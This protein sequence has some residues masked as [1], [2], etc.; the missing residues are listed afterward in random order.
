M[1]GVMAM[2]KHTVRVNERGVRIG[3]GHHNA[4]LTDAE[5]VQL[6]ADRGPDGA[7]A[8]SYSALAKRYGVSKSCVASLVQ[9]RTRE[10]SGV[11]V[12]RVRVVEPGQNIVVAQIR[13]TLADRALLI[14]LGG[15]KWVRKALASVRNKDRR[16]YL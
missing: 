7:P 15:A 5:V 9:G 1:L 3:E 13:L 16:N 8:M 12:Q 4:V 14:R 6:L 10:I 11:A 2:M